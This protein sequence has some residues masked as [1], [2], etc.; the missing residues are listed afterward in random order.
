MSYGCSISFKKINP[1]D[2]YDFLVQFKAE[3]NKNLKEIAR[4]QYSWIP[5]VRNHVEVEK[6]FNKIPKDEIEASKNWAKDL[7]TYRYFY[8]KERNLLGIYGLPKQMKHLFDGTVYFQNSVDQDYDR[9]AYEGIGDFLKI[10]D[11]CM[12]MSVDELAEAYE[13]ALSVVK[14][15]WKED[16]L[17]WHPE[18]LT[19]ETV[20]Y[21]KKTVAYERIWKIVEFSLWNENRIVYF[22]LFGYYEIREI[23]LV[24]VTCH[25]EAVLRQKEMFDKAKQE[26][27]RV[28]FEIDNDQLRVF[29]DGEIVDIINGDTSD[30]TDADFVEIKKQVLLSKT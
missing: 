9:E 4:D 30:L 7:F 18:G 6:D 24:L 25:K 20:D 23:Q 1:E 22:S 17:D 12:D 14:R 29:F 10:Y 11:E 2:V 27:S 15:D 26:Q 3:A 28:T 19:E 21:Y 13:N 16:V 8:I 5:F